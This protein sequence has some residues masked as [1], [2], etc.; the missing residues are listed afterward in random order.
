MAILTSDILTQ[1]HPEV[2]TTHSKTFGLRR[3][4][5]KKRKKKD[6]FKY[7][8]AT[9]DTVDVIKVKLTQEVLYIYFQLNLCCYLIYIM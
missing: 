9:S 2:R 5:I 1:N 4:K 7:S 6:S 8:L 3:Y